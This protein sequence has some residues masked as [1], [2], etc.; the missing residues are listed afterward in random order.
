MMK[1]K[2]IARLIIQNGDV[3]RHFFF[4]FV[5]SLAQ[6]TLEFNIMKHTYEKRTSSHRKQVH[7][8]CVYEIFLFSRLKRNKKKEP[9]IKIKSTSRGNKRENLFYFLNLNGGL[10]LSGRLR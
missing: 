6:L 1:K 10:K 8:C 5:F 7:F 2:K 9:F 4:L 3:S